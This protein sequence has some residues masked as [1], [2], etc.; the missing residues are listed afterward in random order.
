MYDKSNKSVTVE[1]CSDK[2]AQDVISLQQF[3]LVNSTLAFE[4][5]DC[6]LDPFHN[7]SAIG[8]SVYH[9]ETAFGMEDTKVEEDPSWKEDEQDRLSCEEILCDFDDDDNVEKKSDVNQNSLHSD[10]HDNLNVS[11]NAETESDENQTSCHLDADANLNVSKQVKVYT[12]TSGDLEQDLLVPM[13]VAAMEDL[14]LVELNSSNEDV[15]KSCINI[16]KSSCIVEFTSADLATKACALDGM[17]YIGTNLCIEMVRDSNVTIMVLN[18]PIGKEELVRKYLEA[19]FVKAGLSSDGQPVID[20]L[21]LENDAVF[22]K[23]R[24][25]SACKKVLEMEC[26]KFLTTTLIFVEPHSQSMLAS[27]S[28]ATSNLKVAKNQNVNVNAPPLSKTQSKQ[29]ASSLQA[30]SSLVQ[31]KTA[32]SLI[33]SKP[34]SSIQTALSTVQKKKP[35]PLQ[36]DKLADQSINET[37]NV[38]TLSGSEQVLQLKDADYLMKE[39]EGKVLFLNKLIL[40]RRLFYNKQNFPAAYARLMAEVRGAG[41]DVDLPEVVKRRSYWQDVNNAVKRGKQSSLYM[42][43]LKVIFE[44]APL[45]TLIGTEFYLADD[46][47]LDSQLVDP[48]HVATTAAMFSKGAVFSPAASRYLIRVVKS[49]F[50]ILQGAKNTDIFWR[51]VSKLMADKEHYYDPSACERKFDQAKK[52]YRSHK[53]ELLRTGAEGDKQHD[54]WYWNDD[55]HFVMKKDT[56]SN[57]PMTMSMGSS[58]AVAARNMAA[59]DEDDEDDIRMGHSKNN[60]HG[61][62]NL[63]VMR[64]NIPKLKKPK[65]KQD[66]RLEAFLVVAAAMDR[67]TAVLARQS[68][69]N[70][71]VQP[72][73]DDK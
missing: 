28:S 71:S 6:T 3:K 32:T 36:S 68:S 10:A 17:E 60:R 67:R 34:E 37:F 5:A 39:D 12:K 4:S 48:M 22:L 63:P 18:V 1:F 46:I 15:I 31:K 72:T 58:R 21:F 50:D 41:V 7:L 19:S 44:K 26:I 64:C 56:I 35:I 47:Q 69:S 62:D 73:G 25:N 27:S 52:L 9:E 24:D 38:D 54:Q 30:A 40:T 16:E 42:L 55:M 43:P 65:S 20:S 11:K 53:A 45:E 13:I 29:V 59:D 8:N 23:L 61:E 66:A 70:V 33:S 49:N 2:I 57:P 14:Q 51:E